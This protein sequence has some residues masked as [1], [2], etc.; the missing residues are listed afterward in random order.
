[1]WAHGV[2]DLGLDSATVWTLTPRQFGFLSERHAM[3]VRMADRRAGEVVAML[4]NANRDTKKDPEGATWLSFFP[5]HRAEPVAQTDE[6]MLAAMTLW[7][8][9]TAR[10]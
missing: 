3:A 10:A 6:E 2:Y 5:E 9:A 7:A 4:Y 8:K 1:M